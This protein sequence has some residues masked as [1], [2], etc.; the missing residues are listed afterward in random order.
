M[1]NKKE[2]LIVEQILRYNLVEKYGI[3]KE[4]PAGLIQDILTQIKDK[5]ERKGEIDANKLL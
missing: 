2:L 1:L 5:L 4:T 3:F